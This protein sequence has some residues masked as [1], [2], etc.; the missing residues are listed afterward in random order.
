MSNRVL[1]QAVKANNA[2]ATPQR[3]AVEL[4]REQADRQYLYARGWRERSCA[5]PWR[6]ELR[7][8]RGCF[9]T[10]H[11]AVALQRSMEKK[12]EKPAF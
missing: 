7:K 10:T 9:Y 2:L 1:R 3:S 5:G 4:S 11:D 8:L 12:T 6:W